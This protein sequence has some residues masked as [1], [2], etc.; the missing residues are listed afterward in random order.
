[1]KYSHFKGAILKGAIPSGA[2]FVIANAII[3]LAKA[4]G[5][6][7]RPEYV[8]PVILAGQGAIAYLVNWIKNKKKV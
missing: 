4:R 6:E 3:A 5:I 1:M 7:L 2:V 8:Y